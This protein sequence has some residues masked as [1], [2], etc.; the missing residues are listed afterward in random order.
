MLHPYTVL[1][2]F[3]STWVIASLTV[4]PADTRLT[5]IGSAQPV[6]KATG[7]A[8]AQQTLAGFIIKFTNLPKEAGPAM[9]DMGGTM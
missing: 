7:H 8:P 9:H 1:K 3:L 6:Q 2:L 4:K 5:A